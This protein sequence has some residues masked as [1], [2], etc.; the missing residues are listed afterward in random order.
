MKK[1]ESCPNCG[2][3]IKAGTF[4]SNNLLDEKYMDFIKAVLPEAREDYCDSCSK[5]PMKQAKINYWSKIT[6]LNKYIEN[7]INVMPILTTHIPFNWEY[8]S[9]GIVTGQS[10]TGTGLISEFTSDLTDFFG[11]QS[12][13]FNRK[14]AQGENLCFTQ[15]RAKT[16]KFGGNAIIATDIDY[17]EA[18]AAK[19]MLMVCAAGTAVNV[20]NIEVLG[21]KQETLKTLVEKS[22]E[23]EHLYE[24]SELAK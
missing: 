23:I 10:V 13:S 5:E 21:D 18:G 3:A 9:L 7:N 16:L 2:K 12:G 4:K 14:L 19:G 22:L 17:G 20:E 24:F 1:F 11:K 6:E 8:S 15:L